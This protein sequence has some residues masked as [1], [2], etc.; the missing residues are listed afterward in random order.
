MG[1]I[2][3]DYI[4]ERYVVIST[5]RKKRPHEFKEV[6]QTPKDE[7]CFFCP[8]MED[9]T[10]P[11]IGRL[12][13][14]KWKLRWFPNKFYAVVQEGNPNLTTDNEFFTYSSNYGKHEV[15]VE[16]PD[17]QE[18]LWDLDV[19]DIKDVL[20]VYNE[21]VKA[22]H[23]QD[24]AIKY[25]A[26]FKNHGL[27]G[28]TSLVHSHSQIISLNH[29]PTQVQE[30][31]DACK[32]HDSCPY[33]KIVEIE[34]K[35]DRRCFENDSFVAF[36]PYASRFN[37]EVWVFP[38]KHINSLDDIDDYE[39]LAD[40]MHKIVSKLKELNV[41]YNYFLHYSPEGEDLHFHIEVVP[42]IATW[43]GFELSTAEAI[44]GV[45]PE[46][47]AAFYRGEHE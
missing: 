1:E 26:V 21:R 11:E 33:C 44:N 34:N 3:K 19:D 6:S 30:E 20:S 15:I 40:I 37:F 28:G 4:L 32:R 38:K 17:H 13:G 25:V 31:I 24:Q 23:S 14:K 18:Q 5:L 36:T 43:A 42:R 7:K 22:I 35:S 12:G 9:Q 47:A 27:K 29:I 39:D 8:G 45:T 46:D 16:T 10:P 2:R 41:S